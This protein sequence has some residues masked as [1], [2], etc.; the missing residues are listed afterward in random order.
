MRPNGN[1][2]YFKQVFDHVFFL[3]RQRT[4]LSNRRF[5]IPPLSQTHLNNL[6]Y[7]AASPPACAN[8]AF[9]AFMVKIALKKLG[10]G[11]GQI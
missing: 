8:G 2:S 5:H 11:L 10:F 9:T 7:A 4:G 6:D 3:R 1:P